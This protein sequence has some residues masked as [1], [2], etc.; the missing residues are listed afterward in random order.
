MTSQRLFMY[1]WLLASLAFCGVLVWQDFPIAIA[2]QPLQYA[3]LMRLQLA[4][5]L[6]PANLITWIILVVYGIVS[7]WRVRT[8]WHRDRGAMYVFLMCIISVVC[9]I[10]VLL[11]AR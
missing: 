11:V 9:F 6:K 5:L 1:S 4:V 3:A 10:A 2:N 8:T 7:T